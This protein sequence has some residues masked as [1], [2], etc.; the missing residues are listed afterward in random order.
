MVRR[1]AGIAGKRVIIERQ[2]W[3]MRGMTLPRAPG[4]CSRP[5]KNGF[6]S[7]RYAEQ[8]AFAGSKLGS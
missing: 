7:P 8:K 1:R 6:P 2:G 3:G 4:V 5:V